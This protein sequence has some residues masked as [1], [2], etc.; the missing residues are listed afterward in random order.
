MSKPIADARRYAAA[1]RRS[2]TRSSTIAQLP[3]DIYAAFLRDF[4]EGMGYEALCE[5]Y[6]P[7]IDE[8]NRGATPVALI[9]GGTKPAPRVPHLSTA[10]ISRWWKN[11]EGPAAAEAAERARAV[12]SYRDQMLAGLDA[13]DALQAITGFA[14]MIALKRAGALED[15]PIKDLGYLLTSLK[16]VQAKQQE[17]ELKRQRLEQDNTRLQHQIETYRAK[18]NQDNNLTL[19]APAKVYQH[20][21]AQILGILH[22]FG[23]LRPL[24]DKYARNVSTR[25]ATESERFDWSEVVHAGR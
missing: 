25:L 3:P 2:L 9:G 7:I 5:K 22:T 10:A 14:E 19:P 16:F 15:I 13:G 8:Y 23:E 24:L 4:R 12:E 6:N 17:V 21:A 20:V 18:V 11:K 1:N